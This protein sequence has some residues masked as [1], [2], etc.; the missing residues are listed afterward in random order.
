M[1]SM[2]LALQTH[3]SLVNYV[4]NRCM[5]FDVSSAITLHYNQHTD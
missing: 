5:A 1:R 3:S 4:L 2:L